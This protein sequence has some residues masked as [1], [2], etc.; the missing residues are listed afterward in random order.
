MKR[1]K[2]TNLWKRM[3]EAWLEASEARQLVK[4]DE[5]I[6]VVVEDRGEA[7]APGA[8]TKEAILRF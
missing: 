2:F 3:E 1:E 5:P 7:F 8:F 6:T 4:F